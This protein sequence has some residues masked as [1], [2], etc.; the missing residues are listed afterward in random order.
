[1][2]ASVSS[3][4]S[5]ARRSASATPWLTAQ[6]LPVHPSGS[7]RRADHRQQLRGCRGRAP[8]RRCRRSSSHPPERCETRRRSPA[9]PAT[10]SPGPPLRLR[11]A[12]E[13][14]PTTPGSG[15]AGASMAATVFHAPETAAKSEQ[16]NPHRQ[17]C[18][19][20]QSQ[21]HVTYAPGTISLSSRR[22]SSMPAASACETLDRIP[23]NLNRGCAGR[24]RM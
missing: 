2:S 18:R 15:G 3:R 6:S 24:F 14:P 21:Y 7:E 9:P 19:A 4:Y 5:G 8:L 12:P 16:V 10:G 11:C 22:R 13:S 17:G 1:M 20:E 23:C